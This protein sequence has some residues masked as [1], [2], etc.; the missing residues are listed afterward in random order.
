MSGYC[1]I[2][3][4]SVLHSVGAVPLVCDVALCVA[5]GGVSNVNFDVISPN[6]LEGTCINNEVSCDFSQDT[7]NQRSPSGYL[8]QGSNIKY[9]TS[10][11]TLHDKS[12]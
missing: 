7:Y 1:T 2:L 10:A 3:K 4:C 12:S 9:S 6:L 11:K 8:I 5:A